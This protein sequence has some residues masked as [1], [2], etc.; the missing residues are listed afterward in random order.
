MPLLMYRKL[1]LLLANYKSIVFL[2]DLSNYGLKL[3]AALPKNLR[4]RSLA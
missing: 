1:N 2:Q 3:T 4:A